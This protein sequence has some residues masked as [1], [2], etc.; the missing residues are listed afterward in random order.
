MGARLSGQS[1]DGR[2]ILS[3]T[4]LFVPPASERSRYTPGKV[5]HPS[6][7][8]QP[9]VRT[10]PPNPPLYTTTTTTTTSSPSRHRQIGNTL[11]GPATLRVRSTAHKRPPGP[12]RAEHLGRVAANRIH[13]QRR[14]VLGT[15]RAENLASPRPGTFYSRVHH[16]RQ[17]VRQG[18]DSGGAE[19]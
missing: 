4:T 1:S 19:W 3:V 16:P 17:Q 8:R 5:T 10:P 18:A 13:I 7:L 2:L 15:R 14:T 12:R 6:P 9:H 11:S